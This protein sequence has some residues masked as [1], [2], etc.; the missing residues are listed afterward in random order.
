MSPFV[1]L[2]LPSG[3]ARAVGPGAIIGRSFAADVRLEDGRVSEVHALVSLHGGDFV[4]LPLGG[5]VRVRGRVV[6][7][8]TL[9]PG[10]CFELP[11]GVSLSVTAVHRPAELL[12]LEGPGVP[13]RVLAGVLSVCTRPRLQLVAGVRANAA[14]LV[15]SDGLSWFVR[16]HGT[17]ARRVRAGDELLSGER[18]LRFVTQS[19]TD[20]GRADH[21]RASPPGGLRVFCRGASVHLWPAGAS[22]PAVV[23]GQSAAL[24]SRLLSHRGP[25]R[26]ESAAHALWPRAAADD[27]V[28]HRLDVVL[29]KLRRRLDEAGLRR[30]LVTAHRNGF[31]ELVLYP[32]DQ[33]HE[34]HFEA[35]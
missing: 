26:W 20:A 35:R 25:V 13:R 8:V 4:L 31:L 17:K 32:A 9:V 7:R 1:E 6:P 30:D 2:Q 11:G 3:E 34:Q 29:G 16:E 21:G 18:T 19:L 28:R 33:V 22:A 27:V 23:S 10:S 12:A 24:L 15:F 5:Q 14:A